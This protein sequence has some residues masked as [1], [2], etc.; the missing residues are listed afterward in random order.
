M[1]R[2]GERGVGRRLE[3]YRFEIALVAIALVALAIRIVFIVVVDPTVPKLG[4]ASAYHLLAEQL[5]RGD[6]YIR[7]FDNLLLHLQ[8]P[9]A[10]YPPLFP[11]LLAVPARLGMHSVEQQRIVLAF[12]GAGTVVLVGV[13]GRRVASGAAGLVAAALAAVYPMLFLSEATL[14]SESLYVMLVTLVLICAYRAYDDPSP[15]RF[16]VFGAAAGMATLVRAEGLLLG[17]VVAITVGLV[18]RNQSPRERVV[19]VAVAIGV[20]IL[21][22]VPWTIRNA[23]R[24]D[25]FVP[26]SNNAAT[27]VDGANCDLT[28]GGAQ[29]GLWRETFSGTRL[30][31]KVS[32]AQGC[33]EGFDISD[34]D[35]DEADASR[36]HLRDGASYARHHLGS[37]PKVAAVRVLRTWGLYSPEQQV[38]FESLEGRPRAWQMRGTVMYWVL[39][40]LVVWGAVLLRRRHRVIA[41]LVATAV[42][43]TIGAALTYGQQRFRVAAEPAILVL[44]AVPLVALLQAA[45]RYVAAARASAP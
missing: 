3:R 18:L 11:L 32:Q 9:T 36:T 42:T 31:I 5:A 22:V 2:P 37:L 8:R 7:P 20:A 4:D 43:V 35:F 25:A 28:Y 45:R 27:L 38:S 29:L 12:V 41:P 40:P 15:A 26:V 39:A 19:R 14:M 1:T 21:V 13:L 23:V 34:P 17:A 24:L 10:E 44:A 6:G 33:F 30:P 16:V